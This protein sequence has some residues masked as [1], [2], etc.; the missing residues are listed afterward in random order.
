MPGLPLFFFVG[1]EPCELEGESAQSSAD[2]SA[3][4]PA[5]PP[6]LN[7]RAGDVAHQPAREA[8]VSEV[9]DPVAATD[10]LQILLQTSA[11]AKALEDQF[12]ELKNR[13]PN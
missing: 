9:S 1:M 11:A 5:A 6:A 12:A 3:N 10:P 8:D 7:L 4:L 13:Q 2:A